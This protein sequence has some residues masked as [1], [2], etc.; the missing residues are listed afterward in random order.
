MSTSVGCHSSEESVVSPMLHSA[1]IEAQAG[2]EIIRI[3]KVHSS[4]PMPHFV[5]END[6]KTMNGRFEDFNE[7][8]DGFINFSV[9]IDSSNGTWLIEKHIYL[10]YSCGSRV[11]RISS[12]TMLRVAHDI[13]SE[14]MQK[15][16]SFHLRI[17]DNLFSYNA[18]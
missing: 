4:L 15:Y 5:H 13:D 10:W 7:T 11:Q 8:I 3:I 16:E 18:R 2:S 6:S 17:F 1:T 14:M 12:F 9:S